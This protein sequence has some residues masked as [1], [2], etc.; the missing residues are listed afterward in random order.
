MEQELLDTIVPSAAAAAAAAVDVEVAGTLPPG[1][2]A[3]AVPV[4]TDGPL[5]GGHGL[6]RDVLR[7]AGFTSKVGSTLALPP[8]TGTVPVLVG[9]GGSSAVTAAVVRD[10]AAAFARAVPRDAVLGAEVSALAGVPVAQ[11]AAAVVEGILMSRH[12]WSLATGERPEVPVTRIV[13]VA[14]DED[15]EQARE[16]VRLGLVGA[17]VGL[18]ARD[19]ATCPAEI[20]TSEVIADVAVAV[21]DRHGLEVEVHDRASLEALG[22]GGILGVNRG[23]AREP[24]MV[25]VHYRPEGAPAGHLALVGK[26][27]MFDS[28]GISLKPGDES[29]S[30]MKNDM[31]GA[32]DVLAAMSGLR[33]LGCTTE[34][35]GYLMCTDNM[36]GPTAMQLGD[37]LTM[38][39][40]TTVEVL[41]TDAEG[42]LVM[43][44][45]LVLA[46]E[47]G[48]QAVIDIA[49]LTGACLRALGT[50]V[51]GVMG[52]DPGL[53]EV[54]RR[55]GE[56]VDEPVWEFPLLDIYRREL[57]S[58]VADL[59]NIGGPNAGQITAGLFLKE[60]VD[61]V[62]WAH[63]DIA[64][65]AQAPAEDRWVR[66]GPTGFG[67][68]LLAQASCGFS[69]A[70]RP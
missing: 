59:R 41:N 55:A 9:L 14:S 26:G 38:R 29:H 56:V 37:V 22:C 57:D 34:V 32:G 7:R 3:V 64:G 18:L 16:G 45:A 23:S 53:V 70:A 27:I 13:V 42:R 47:A 6:D 25:V 39:G 63:I 68:R 20:L 52:T 36:P 69:G 54:V 2:D 67:A 50:R 21:G 35:T 44:D 65:T 30:Q 28:G 60:F 46:R 12:R 19:L 17:R 15:A 58:D 10:A 11:V 49:T 5:P 40:G 51:A 33:D 43:A 61:D 8:T 31:S 48:A 66:R 62:P 4:T 24:R 1:L